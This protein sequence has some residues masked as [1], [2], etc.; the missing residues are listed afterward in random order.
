MR[1][2]SLASLTL[3]ELAALAGLGLLAVCYLEFAGAFSRHMILHIALMT[4][5]APLL[6]SRLRG[7]VALKPVSAGPWR[8]LAAAVTQL[9]VFFAWHSP[10][11][12]TLAMAGD[13]GAAAMQLSLLIVSSWFWMCI[14]AASTHNAWPAVV[15][16]VV[17]GKLYCLLAI[18]LVFAPRM[19]YGAGHHGVVTLADQQLAGLLMITACPLTYVLA[20]VVL[21]A[22][23]FQA[24]IGEQPRS[25]ESNQ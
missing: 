4:G 11:G 25:A 7:R 15:A 14:F 2:G 16:L 18:L 13:G 3:I 19:L 1:V 21:V 22:R 10:P 8:L 20:A 23:W 9:V 5:V 24:L 17:T 12:M 6:A